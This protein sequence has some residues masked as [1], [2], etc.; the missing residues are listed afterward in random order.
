MAQASTLESLLMPGEVIK[1]HA[2][3][4]N[5]C[6]RCHVLI[7]DKGQRRFCLDCHKEVRADVEQ[8]RGFHGRNKVASQQECQE[9]HTEHKGRDADV[10][11]LNEATFDH[12]Y[13]DFE[14]RGAHR[15]LACATCHKSGKKHREAPAQCSN[16]HKEDNPHKGRLGKLEQN[17]V[18][19]HG[20]SLWS[21]IDFDH[22]KTEFALTGKHDTTLCAA[23]HPNDRVEKTPRQCVACHRLND[24]HGG[25]N[26]EQC[27]KCHSTRSWKKIAFDHNKDTKFA[28]NGR[29][30]KARC[31]SCH[32]EDP[33]K[34]KLKRNCHACHQ[35][36]DEHKG[37]YGLRCETCHK[38][39]DWN[40]TK[41]DHQTDTKFALHGKHVDT[42]CDA[43]H[44]ANL[45]DR[46]LPTNCHSCHDLD[47]SHNGEQGDRCERCHAPSGWRKQVRFEH[48]VTHFPLIGI[49]A[50]VACEECHLSPVYKKTP[51][52]CNACHKHQDPH[53]AALGIQCESCHTPNG[54]QVWRFDHNLESEFRID[55]AHK[56]VHCDACHFEAVETMA[57]DPRACIACHRRDDAHRG[58]FGPRCG[59]CHGTSSFKSLNLQQVQHQA[60]Q[61]NK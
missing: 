26:G 31:E 21:R 12:K 16:C 36:D 39:T 45:Y 37:R 60:P 44:L 4:E 1:G 58:Q 8:Q 28:L 59:R 25:R 19:C 15:N 5:E 43:C 54:W 22:D 42:A 48:D 23:C 33:Y 53:K 6:H 52:D 3:Y 2:K 18:A 55:G 10:V 20:Q 46:K 24:V 13:S 38:D 47:D 51:G 11:K 29:H 32:R 49:H 9:C 41:F 30:E 61:T 17:C 7:R 35:Y 57:R 40:T 56:K 27:K 34:V 50:A 14:L